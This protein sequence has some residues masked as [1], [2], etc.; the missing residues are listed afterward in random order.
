MQPQQPPQQQQPPP[1]GAPGAPPPGALPPTAVFLQ[2][3]V[4]PPS[5][6]APPAGAEPAAAAAAAEPSP[7][8]EPSP[9][10]VEMLEEWPMGEEAEAVDEA[11]APLSAGAR[12]LEEVRALELQQPAAVID[13]LLERLGPLLR[14]AV[15]ASRPG[16]ASAASVAFVSALGCAEPPASASASASASGAA[17][18]PLAIHLQGNGSCHQPLPPADEIAATR[19]LL[20][21]ARPSLSISDA[22][23][24]ARQIGGA[25]RRLG[26]KCTNLLLVT[27]RDPPTSDCVLGVFECLSGGAP[28]PA[29]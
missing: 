1:W 29:A 18:G 3:P 27:A 10:P 13:A 20:R 17:A 15:T 26:A 25:R 24:I 14:R 8:R 4:Q 6:P 9:E 28:I 7:E 21:S 12:M 22:S 5:A 2:Q 16:P 19:S 11:G 23:F